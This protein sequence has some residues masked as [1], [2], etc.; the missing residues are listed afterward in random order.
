MDAAQESF[1]KEALELAGYN[2]LALRAMV[3]WAQEHAHDKDAMRAAS[4]AWGRNARLF[5][6]AGE[7]FPEIAEDSLSADDI[8]MRV[9]ASR[10]PCENAEDVIAA[11]VDR[12][13]SYY[14]L[15]EVVDA[16]IAETKTGRRCAPPLR[17]LVDVARTWT[18]PSDARRIREL[19]NVPE[20]ARE[21]EKG[22][23]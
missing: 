1:Y 21:W 16:L 14:E 9:Y 13:M 10:L 2:A 19:C 6:R 17:R 8:L 5:A 3:Q 15:R 11:S 7:Y 18:K 20:F 12:T 4:G 22:K 23:L